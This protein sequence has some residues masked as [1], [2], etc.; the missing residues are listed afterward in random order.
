MVKK[1]DCWEFKSCGREPGGA[2]AE[3]YGV[4][5]AATAVEGEGVNDGAMAGRICWAVSGTFCGG[6]V[7]GNFAK[8][9]LSCINCDFYMRVQA[10]QGTDNFILLMTG[11]K[12]GPSRK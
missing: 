5:P 3:E 11:Q 4:C 10:E 9:E 6:T 2:H 7:Q 1:M 8:E 12:Y